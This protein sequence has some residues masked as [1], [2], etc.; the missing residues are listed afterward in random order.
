MS[1]HEN[2]EV[3]ILKDQPGRQV[4]RIG[5]RIHR[6]T[7]WWTPAVH[8]LLGFLEMRGFP[9]SPRIVGFDEEGREV[10][11]HIPGAAGVR[12]WPR[13]VPERGLKQ[14]AAML[15]RYHDAVD[16]FSPAPGAAWAW[17]DAPKRPGEIIC[18][19]DFGPWNVVWRGE[20]A[21]GI[22]DWDFAGPGVPMHDVAYALDYCA[23]F[24]DD[25]TAMHWMS[26][27]EPPNRRRRIEIFAEEYGLDS[28]Q[29][30]VDQVIARQLLDIGRIR[31][32]AERGLEPQATWVATGVL[33]QLEA[34]AAWTDRHR[35]LFE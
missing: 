7:N 16:G 28:T 5:R 32:L 33:E 15:R 4:I 25:E 27:D 3:E 24:R 19:G 10:L 26:Y 34:R 35:R 14:V 13:V 20:R 17:T 22:I 6:S 8:Q 2:D 21:V 18:H 9:Y 1:S 12:S 23:P 31:L 30:I 11:T 29:G